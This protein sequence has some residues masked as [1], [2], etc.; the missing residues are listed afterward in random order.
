[1]PPISIFS[2]DGDFL[3]GW[4]DG[5]FEGLHQVV[6]TPDDDVFVV[7]ND[8]HQI[9]KFTTEGELVMTIG[10]GRP[11]LNAPFNFPADVAISQNGDIYIADGDANTC[12]HKF[13]KEGEL[14]LSWGSAGKGPGQISTPHSVAVDHQERVY[15]GDRDT[16]RILVF[17]STGKSIREWTDVL[18]RPTSIFIDNDQIMYVSDLN[19]HI[20]IYDLEGR[21]LGRGHT[22]G[23][24]HSICGD[25]NGN[26]YIVLVEG[27][28]YIER[29]E[30]V[31]A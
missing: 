9:F 15:V 3:G 14:L 6:I 19:C 26:L 21:V 10:D 22:A 11:R 7:D 31:E 8:R 13:N 27:F 4:G 25:A 12:V 28:P 18:W 30:P 29:W 20:N 1:M 23:P 24:M 17:D 16:G 2:P 5:F